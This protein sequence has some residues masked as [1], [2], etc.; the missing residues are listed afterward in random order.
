MKLENLPDFAKPFKTKGYDIRCDNGVF[1]LYK[2]SSIRVEDK[3]YPQLLQEYVGIIDPIKG[4]IQKK[5]RIQ[6]VD[7]LVEYGLSHF[8]L[9]NL[10]RTLVRTLFNTKTKFAMPYILLAIDLFVHDSYCDTAI[11]SSYDTYK[12]R[13]ELIKFRDSN[14]CLDKVDKLNNKIKKELPLIMDSDDVRDLTILLKLV[15][16]NRNSENPNPKYCDR[17]IDIIKKWGLKI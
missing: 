3:P 6:Q 1:K 11:D 12:K 10:K 17:I 8:I 13:D 7:D 16:V 2:I 15:E 9:V 4:L 5:V 14:D